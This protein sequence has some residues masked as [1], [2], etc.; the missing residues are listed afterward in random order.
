MTPDRVLATYLIETPHALERAAAV[1]AGEQSR[2]RK[3]VV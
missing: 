2:D 1:L 3:S